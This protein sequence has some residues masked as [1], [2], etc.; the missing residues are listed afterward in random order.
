MDDDDA[1]YVT[2]I[3]VEVVGSAPHAKVVLSFHVN[4]EP[5]PVQLFLSS[6]S[7]AEIGMML[8]EAALVAVLDRPSMN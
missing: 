2:E 1:G 6:E 4:D 8:T 7:A 3:G 5:V